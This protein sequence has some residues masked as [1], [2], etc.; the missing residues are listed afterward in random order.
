MNPLLASE[1]AIKAVAVLLCSSA[2]TTNPTRNAC[3]HSPVET[4]SQP[5]PHI[6]AVAAQNPAVTM[7][8]PHSRIPT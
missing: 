1:V 7:C 2:V 8:V 6:A 5:P 3:L 4:A